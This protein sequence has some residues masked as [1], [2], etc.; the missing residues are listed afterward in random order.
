MILDCK[1]IEEKE[2]DLQVTHS[3]PGRITSQ[4]RDLIRRQETDMIELFRAQRSAKSNLD[5]L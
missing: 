5:R 2:E 3:G 1:T 4:E